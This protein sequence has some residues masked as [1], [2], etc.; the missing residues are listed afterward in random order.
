MTLE[1][2]I[3]DSWLER[4]DILK[5]RL[6]FKESEKQI[7]KSKAEY[8]GI[9]YDNR[10]SGEISS[11]ATEKKYNEVANCD[12]DIEELKRTIERTENEIKSAIGTITDKTFREIL[13][14]YYIEHKTFAT[15]SKELH[16]CKSSIKAKRLQALDALNIDPWTY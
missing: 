11:N 7:K 3:K 2:Q 12:K 14:K 8:S 16:Y 4:T 9:S 6:A 15:I 1:Q 10:G 5:K 13:Q